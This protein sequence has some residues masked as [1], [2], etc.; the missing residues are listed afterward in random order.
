[1]LKKSSEVGAGRVALMNAEQLVRGPAWTPPGLDLAAGRFPLAVEAHVIA[2]T[3]RLV[4]GATT[5]TTNARYYAVHALAALEAEARDLDDGEA[6]VL[7]RRL[8]VVFA[9][10]ALLADDAVISSPHGAGRIAPMLKTGEIDIDVLATPGAKGHS[11]TNGGFSGPYRGSEI[12]L[13]I[14]SPDSR[15]RPG[16]RCNEQAIRSG[17]R[18]L[19]DASSASTLTVS[20]LRELAH[21]SLNAAGTPDGDWLLDL[22]AKPDPV[23]GLDKSDS[24]R[25]ATVRLLLAAIDHHEGLSFSDAFHSF[26]AF[27]D[28]A[29]QDPRTR[30]FAE[31]QAWRGVILRRYSVGAWRRLWQWI[32][33][34]IEGREVAIRDLASVCAE[35]FQ[36]ETMA[37]FRSRLPPTA[38]NGLPLR[39]EDEILRS[40]APVPLA[41]VAVLL[42]GGQRA[43]ELS[44]QAADAFLGRHTVLGPGWVAG[45][46]AI[47]NDRPMRDFIVELVGQLVK[48][49]QRIAYKKAKLKDGRLWVPTRVYERDGML[50]RTSAE[51]GGDVGLRIDQLGGILASLGAVSREGD[52]WSLS[53]KGRELL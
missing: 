36:P 27:S 5:V 13:A 26:V 46:T 15:L 52:G 12:A 10:A 48:R 3:G 4:P 34:Q 31:A 35:S 45:Q 6:L 22:F 14:L 29:L 51:G 25:R 33:S 47:W 17:L 19:V 16:E 40:I 23:E 42:S 39:A 37:A 32:V 53:P 20:A 44:G 2:M 1:M 30:E 9:A 11:D 49:S 21:L 28:G 8:E 7:V 38:E 24:A 41:E 50:V 18:G 43:A